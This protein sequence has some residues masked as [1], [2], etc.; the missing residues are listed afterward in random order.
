MLGM[1][2]PFLVRIHVVAVLF[3]SYLICLLHKSCGKQAMTF[4]PMTSFSFPA[5]A[6]TCLPSPLLRLGFHITPS[7]VQSCT[8]LNILVHRFHRL[9]AVSKQRGADRKKSGWAPKVPL[10]GLLRGAPRQVWSLQA[11]VRAGFLL[12]CENMRLSHLTR[13]VSNAVL[14]RKGAISAVP[15]WDALRTCLLSMSARNDSRE[16]QG[17]RLPRM[18]TCLQ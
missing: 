10:P 14:R 5:L 13:D 8:G 12:G 15:R 17:G 16:I 2:P 3:F 9:P 11:Q 1:V 6:V 7:T 4:Y 18:S